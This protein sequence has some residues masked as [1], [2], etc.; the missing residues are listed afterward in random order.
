[1]ETEQMVAAQKSFFAT[2][3]TRSLAFRAAALARLQD[4][5]RRKDAEICAALEEDLGKAPYESY[6]SEI[7]IVLG[8]VRGALRHLS[9]WTKPRRVKTALAAVPAKSLLYPEPYGVTLIMAPWNY[10]FQLSLVP[11]IGAIAAGNC[12]VVK[13]SAYAP[14]TSA[15][16]QRMVQECFDV[17]H[18]AVVEGGREQNTRLLEQRF[19]FIFFTGSVAVGKTVIEKAARYLTPVC[20][21]LG[22]K[23]PCIVDE[24]ADIPLAAR[25]ILFGKLMNAGQTC[26]APDYLLVQDSVK[27]ALL[28]AL[29]KEIAAVLGPVPLQN[30]E[31]PKIVNRKH[32][33]RLLGLVQGQTIACGGADDGQMRIEPTILDKVDPASPV[34]QEE[35]FGPILP[36]LTYQ[37][38]GQAIGFVTAREK[39]LALYLF[40]REKTVCRRV[41][42][43]CSFGGGCVNDTLLHIANPRLPFGGVGNSGMGSYHGRYSFDTFTHYKSVVHKGAWPD[44]SMRYHPYTAAKEKWLRRVLK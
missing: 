31:W 9:A 2:G 35:I 18:V 10:P 27:P 21:E 19:D 13:P 4:A 42:R 5:I 24:T 17:G 22:G 39:P 20:L 32:F 43:E 11:L 41:L 8:E 15:L 37:E 3:A 33:E 40:S 25:R 34:M 6:A 14:A 16:L 23:S 12:A 26:I 44:I 29:R 7:G 30:P 36:V 1:M 38:I 28:D